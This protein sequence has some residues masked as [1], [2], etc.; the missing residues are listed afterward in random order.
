MK[1]NRAILALLIIASIAVFFRTA[2]LSD[3]AFITLRVVDNW[4][5]GYGLTF[6]PPERVQAY[7]HPLW[8]FAMT[9]MYIIMR[10]GYFTLLLLSL[11]VSV[12]VIVLFFKTSDD[13]SCHLLWLVC[14]HA[15][16]SL[17]GF[18]HLRA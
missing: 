15:L 13:L 9:F 2:W 17:R 3:D 10:D 14:A 7:T 5:H 4:V 11:V 12:T 1:N 16:Q 18:F 6:N 8:M